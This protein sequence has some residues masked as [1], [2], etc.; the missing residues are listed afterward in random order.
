M[1]VLYADKKNENCFLI[2]FFYTLRFTPIWQ[3][4]FFAASCQNAKSLGGASLLIGVDLAK[5]KRQTTKGR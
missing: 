2:R 1:N 5:D 3:T 4:G